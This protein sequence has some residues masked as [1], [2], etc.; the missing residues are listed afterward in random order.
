MFETATR[1]GYRYP[2]VQGLAT[3]EDL[4]MLPLTSANKASLNNTAKSLTRQIREVGEEDFVDE[5]PANTTLNNKLDIVKYI[6]SVKKAE[7]DARKNATAKKLHNE[8]ILGII[9]KKQDAELEGKSITEL[10]AEM[11]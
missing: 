10:M 7:R 8:K 6:I 1:A 4:W 2:T 3:T 11:E 9:A 5:T